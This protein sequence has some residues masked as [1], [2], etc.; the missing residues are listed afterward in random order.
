[1]IYGLERRLWYDYVMVAI[2]GHF[3]GKVFV[4]DEPVDLPRNQSVI[5]HV[6]LA[7]ASSSAPN[8]EGLW[9]SLKKY[10]GSIEGPSDWSSE[11]DH[12]LYGTPKKSS[13]NG[14]E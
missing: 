2:R 11:H 6:Q 3:D 1:V 10:E 7:E 4:P 13:E 14:N 12:Y 9:T 5:L 8:S